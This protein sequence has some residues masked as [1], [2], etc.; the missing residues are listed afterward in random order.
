MTL[1]QAIQADLKDLPN[2]LKQQVADY[3]DF[4]KIKHATQKEQRYLKRVLGSSKGKYRIADNFDE[5]L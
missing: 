5:S 4:L 1:E 2:N 3:I